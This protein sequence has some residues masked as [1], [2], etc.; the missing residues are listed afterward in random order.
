[1][2]ISA[3]L[4]IC[5]F[6]IFSR[7]VAAACLGVMSVSA[8]PVN[9]GAYNPLS[10]SEKT[11]TGQV[12]VTCNLLFGLGLLPSF[13]VALSTGTSGSYAPR[14]MANGAQRLSYN[15]YDDAGSV[16]GNGL[17]GT[18]LGSF[19]GVLSLGTLNFPVKGRIPVGQDVASGAYADT[20]T[21]LV[22]F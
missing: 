1:M 17:G 5:A 10:A 20:I 13:T 18:V 12:S 15:L 8:V 9:F 6:I 14:K 11:A 22:D 21:V 4:Y 2:R 19:N 7:S 3:T 16:W